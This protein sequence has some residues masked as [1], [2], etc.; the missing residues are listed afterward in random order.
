MYDCVGSTVLGSS[1][2]VLLGVSTGGGTKF[3]ERTIVGI[4]P[5]VSPVDSLGDS[6]DVIGRV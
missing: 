6:N 4:S 3:E 2:R 5:G 1:V